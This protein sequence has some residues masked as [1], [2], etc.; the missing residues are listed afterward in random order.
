[1]SGGRGGNAGISPHI[2]PGSGRVPRLPAIDIVRGVALA[3]MAIYHFSW[4]LG[5]FGFHGM[6]VAG[7]LGWRIFAR[8]IAGSFLFLVGVS[9]VLAHGNAIRWPAFRRRTIIVTLAAA[10]VSLATWL[11]FAEFFVRFGILHHIAL[12]SVFAL[13]FLRLPLA[14]VITAACMASV[15]PAFAT[16]DVFGAPALV[17]LGLSPFPPPAAD[18]VPLFPWFGLVLAGVAGGRLVLGNEQA[19]GILA[20]PFGGKVW[21]GAGWAG[22]NSLAVYLIHQPVLFGIVYVAALAMPPP[23]PVQSAEVDPQQFIASC[24]LEC[25]PA[26]DQNSDKAGLCRS[27]CTCAAGQIDARD[28]WA[29]VIAGSADP[30]AQE[31][32]H[33]IVA[34]CVRDRAPADN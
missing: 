21:R 26:G 3:A 13:A 24:R 14:I 4:D 5:Y 22:R 19:V 28:L 20:L 23:V 7:D 2:L 25:N 31:A 17:W 11:V 29:G 27:V 33:D 18:Y 15:L 16:L 10:G 1:M 34:G 8:L 9:L 32:V 12:A 6:N 30:G